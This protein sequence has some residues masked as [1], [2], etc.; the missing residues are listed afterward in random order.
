[1]TTEWG[2][3]F[4]A[5]LPEL[6]IFAPIIFMIFIPYHLLFLAYLTFHFPINPAYSLF[7]DFYPSCSD[8]P[9][10]SAPGGTFCSLVQIINIS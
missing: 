1:M 8:P 10:E 9:P 7:I 3:T 6:I 4:E 2:I 5:F